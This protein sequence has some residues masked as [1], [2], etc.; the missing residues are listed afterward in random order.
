MKKI[1]TLIVL[2]LIG[3]NI[4]AQTKKEK[5]TYG[6]RAG[7]NFSRPSLKGSYFDSGEG[8]LAKENQKTLIS[9]NFGGYLNIPILENISVQPGL[10]ISGKGLKIDGATSE[11]FLGTTYY[12]TFKDVFNLMY[13]E[14]PV[15]GVFTYNGFYVG[16]GPYL[17][18]AM[19]GKYESRRTVEGVYDKSEER[20][21]KIG[22]NEQE[23]DVKPFDFGINTIAGYKLD[24]GLSLGLNYGFGL[25]NFRNEESSNYNLNNRVL[26]ILLGYSF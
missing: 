25:A 8:K 3:V 1:Y 11:V 9:Y 5:I 4:M 14:L 2:V 20:D 7:V 19:A 10:N 15:N 17:G 13:L 24:N 21:L 18:Y 26:S 22:N 16:A 12:P 23:D 6:I